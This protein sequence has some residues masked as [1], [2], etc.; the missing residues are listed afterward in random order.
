MSL[1]LHAS[2]RDLSNS[3]DNANSELCRFLMTVINWGIKL[4]FFSKAAA[5][6]LKSS[7]PSTMKIGRK[8]AKSKDKVRVNEH[9]EQGRPRSSYVVCIFSPM[10][11]L[12]YEESLGIKCPM[13][14]C[15]TF[16]LLEIP[17]NSWKSCSEKAIDRIHR[18]LDC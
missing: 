16:Q 9:D 14:F 10:C 8:L 6:T 7:T 12:L 3:A 1:A 17:A 15:P 11:L 13:I 2:N 4:L 5:L 18:R